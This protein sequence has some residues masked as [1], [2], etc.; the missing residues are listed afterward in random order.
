MQTSSN[1]WVRLGLLI[2]AIVALFSAIATVGDFVTDLR[3]GGLNWS[4]A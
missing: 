4:L 2:S 1:G 3:G